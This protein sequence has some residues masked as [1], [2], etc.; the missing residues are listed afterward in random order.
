MSDTRILQALRRCD[1]TAY[2]KSILRPSYDP[3]LSNLAWRSTNKWCAPH[4]RLELAKQTLTSMATVLKCIR[5]LCALIQFE[6]TS[7]GERQRLVT[8]G[9]WGVTLS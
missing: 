2:T 7:D 9:E 4:S 5:D 3:Q 1:H 8:Y 6:E